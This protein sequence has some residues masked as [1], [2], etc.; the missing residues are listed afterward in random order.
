MLW[1]LASQRG[2]RGGVT[3]PASNPSGPPT[4]PLVRARNL[5]KSFGPVEVLRGVD[6]APARGVVR[7]LVDRAV[8]AGGLAGAPVGEA[9]P[10]E[11]VRRPAPRGVHPSPVPDPGSNRQLHRPVEP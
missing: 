7:R 9:R 6:L 4:T 8:P 2:L 11:L 3:D 10:T 1:H 5:R